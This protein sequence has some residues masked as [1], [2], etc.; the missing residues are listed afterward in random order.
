MLLEVMDFFNVVDEAASITVG[1]SLVSELIWSSIVD[2]VLNVLIELLWV[3][4]PGDEH[5]DDAD[6][7]DEDEE[8]GLFASS[9]EVWTEFDN[10]DGIIIVDIVLYFLSG[11]IIY[12][13]N[14]FS[15]FIP[16]LN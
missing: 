3:S 4:S 15:Q 7:G 1:T 10:A 6:L 8:L 14:R 5:K 11:I 2:S 12:T 9:C 16:Y 13:L